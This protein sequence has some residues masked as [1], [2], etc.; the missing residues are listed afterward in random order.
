MNQNTSVQSKWI[1]QPKPNGNAKLR[2]FCF[3]YA[4]SSAVVTYKYFV[5][6]LPEFVE[7][8]PVELPGR[9]TRMGEKLIDN[10][11]E[12]LARITENIGSYLDKPFVFFGHSMGALISYELTK[13]VK[14]KYNACPQ[15]LYISAHKAPFLER[16]GPIMHKLERESFVN[17]LKKMNGIANELL[18][19]T[20]LMDLMIPIIKNDYAV[21]E[22]YTYQGKE[23]INVPITAFGGR[24]DK[25]IHEN[26]LI[27][28]AEVTNHDFNHYLIE[29]GHFFITKE[30][31]N[32]IKLFTNI[33]AHDNA[34]IINQK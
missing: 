31:E 29:G 7:V 22:N 24:Y 26:D 32:F 10:I 18:E 19:H 1:V 21:C 25:D 16:G 27:K 15:K 33:L 12:I 2:L 34:K 8:C 14:D 4:G 6:N 13:K 20:E 23:K 17:E 30:K 9:G 5:D 11:E 28:W 3:P